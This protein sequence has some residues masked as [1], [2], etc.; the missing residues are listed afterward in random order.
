MA[1]DRA[2]EPIAYLGYLLHSPRLPCLEGWQG[3][4]V[5]ISRVSVDYG[6]TGSSNLEMISFVQEFLEER[7]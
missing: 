2:L 4:L 7:V 5:G 3:G 1:T 6:F